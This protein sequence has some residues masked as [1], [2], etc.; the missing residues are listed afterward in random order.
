MALLIPRRFELRAYSKDLTPLGVLV[1][2]NSDAASA[3]FTVEHNGIGT[4]TVTVP[5]GH[6]LVQTLMADGTRL[7]YRYI[8]H[9]GTAVLSMSGPIKADSTSISLR[10]GT[11][12]FTCVS[13]EALLRDTLGWPVPTA[14]LAAQ[15]SEYDTRTGMVDAICADIIVANLITRLGRNVR[16]IP[17]F[18]DGQ[19][20][21]IKSRMQP[22]LDVIRPALETANRGVRLYQWNPGDPVPFGLTGALTAPC[23]LVE[24]YTCQDRPYVNW[25]PLLGIESGTAASTSPSVTRVVV[26]GQGEGTARTFAG[27]TEPTREA[28][29]GS[30]GWVEQFVDA[31]DA[32]TT[33]ELT[34]RATE[35]FTEGAGTTS[36]DVSAVDGDPWVVGVHYGLGDLV[37]VT[38]V[39]GVT[40]IDK[41]RSITVSVD[42]KDGITINPKIGN[43]SPTTDPT[44]VLV[45]SL[46]DKGNRLRSLE[47]RR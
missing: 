31:R 42:G 39:E 44:A 38:P 8:D 47:A 11:V 36:L 45:R 4:G 26:G 27:Y 24:M 2:R 28:T 9:V 21:T 32:A 40:R 30:L 22:V 19:T 6:K 1:V 46:A 3:S 37:R 15:A 33:P 14:S 16:M 13:D 25:T 18:A 41:V 34:Q 35:V 7:Q 43:P 29:W 10:T 17:F 23:V 12:T 20:A 5:I